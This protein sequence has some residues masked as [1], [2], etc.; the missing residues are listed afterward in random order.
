MGE[1]PPP[2][3]WVDDAF[4]AQK[5]SLAPDVGRP[6]QPIPGLQP[7]APRGIPT[8]AEHRAARAQMD[9]A[10]DVAAKLRMQANA[11]DAATDPG[12]HSALMDEFVSADSEAARLSK[13]VSSHVEAMDAAGVSVKDL[14][15]EPGEEPIP[16]RRREGRRSSLSKSERRAAAKQ[17]SDA[18]RAAAKTEEALQAAPNTGERFKWIPEGYQKWVRPQVTTHGL[19]TAGIAAGVGAVGYYLHQ[20]KRD[21][22]FDDVTSH[23]GYEDGHA[24][25]R[26]KKEMREPV[27]LMMP[28]RKMNP[29]VTAELTGNMDNRK[30][31][32]HNMA[33]DKNNYLFGGL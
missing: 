27:P 2:E 15:L 4:E 25:A 21:K 24:Y 19:R 16:E 20:R 14:A 18:R 33:P 5:S 7:E 23:Q 3:E 30:I 1:P 13:V 6:V 9:S 17:A 29:L 22:E 11:L 26:Y 31:G 28:S 12:G 32:H 10:R 8:A